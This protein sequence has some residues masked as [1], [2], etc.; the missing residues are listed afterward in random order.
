MTVLVP[1]PE[2]RT[3]SEVITDYDTL[4]YEEYLSEPEEEVGFMT[5]LR[6]AFWSLVSLRIKAR[7]GWV[8]W[9]D[10]P[11]AELD[12]ER[13]WSTVGEPIHHVSLEFF[14]SVSLE[15]S[16][17]MDCSTRNY[18]RM[19]FLSA[20]LFLVPAA[21]TWI[22][23]QVD[24]RQS[25]CEHLSY[26]EYVCLDPAFGLFIVS[27]IQLFLYYYKRTDTEWLIRNFQTIQT[28]MAVIAVTSMVAWMYVAP[29]I[30]EA[31]FLWPFEETLQIA[32]IY[33]MLV[34]LIKMTWSHT[35]Y[36][37][38]LLMVEILCLRW[39]ATGKAAHRRQC[40]FADPLS[41]ITFLTCVTTLVCTVRYLKERLMRK[42]FVLSHALVV[43]SDRTQRLLNNVLPQRVADQLKDLNGDSPQS[44]ECMFNE[45]VLAERHPA[46]TIVFCDI[47]NFTALSATTPPF[48]LIEMLNSIF[49]AF[50]DIAQAEGLEKIKTI[51][52]AYMAAAGAPDNNPMHA[53]AACRFALRITNY[54]AAVG[55]VQIRCGVDSGPVLAG[56]VGSRRFAYELWGSCVEGAKDMERGSKANAVRISASTRAALKEAQSLGCFEVESDDEGRIFVTSESDEGRERAFSAL[57]RRRGFKRRLSSSAGRSA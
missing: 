47:I 20:M 43:E 40:W 31:S 9:D 6:N 54:M 30:W 37:S 38:L 46:V 5:N 19:P 11:I 10:I 2:G 41:S 49:S 52:D 57:P 45:L 7:L 24:R 56:V 39:I 8:S 35:V 36:I 53:E 48:Q 14:K 3:E 4:T 32:I 42:D 51:G 15:R 21:A 22:R 34:A 44:P 16:F 13:L 1:D 17:Q 33:A 12:R 23:F 28:T 50:D 55:P 27:A 18:R 29:V 26:I 25:F